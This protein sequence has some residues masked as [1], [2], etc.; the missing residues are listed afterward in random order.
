MKALTSPPPWNPELIV[1]SCWSKRK[2]CNISFTL[3]HIYLFV[4]DVD[5]D[6]EPS[7]MCFCSWP[8][9]YIS[10][11]KLLTDGSV[12]VFCN[13]PW[14]KLF[15]VCAWMPNKRNNICILRKRDGLVPCKIYWGYCD[16]KSDPKYL[17]NE[18]I[19][20]LFF[21]ACSM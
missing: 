6:P 15:C 13:L 7:I 21:T 17:I 8:W 20:F 4:Q 10:D 5:F 16:S 14:K 9:L 18:T 12:M 3:D 11:V 19:I 1:S 2:E